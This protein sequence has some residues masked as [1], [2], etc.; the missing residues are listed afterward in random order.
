MTD[1]RTALR[2]ACGAGIRK[3]HLQSGTAYGT[4]SPA[5]IA[6]LTKNPPSVD[7]LEGLWFLPS[8]YHAHDA[9][10]HEAQRIHGE[11]HLLVLDIDTGDLPLDDLKEALKKVIG[12]ATYLIYATKSSSNGNR[13]WRVLV[14]V[15]TPIKGQAYE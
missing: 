3:S 7:K 14:P 12:S 11:F 8:S 10:Q 2:L 15:D 4:I 5:R 9:R 6:A 1:T 13:K